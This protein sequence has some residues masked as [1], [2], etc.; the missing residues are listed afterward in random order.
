MVARIRPDVGLVVTFTRADGFSE[1]I[2]A[3]T[4]ERALRGAIM[5][6]S[7]LDDL[8]AGDRLTVIEANEEAPR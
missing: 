7:R 6:L 1:S 3:G 5:I 8:Q 2:T 4:G